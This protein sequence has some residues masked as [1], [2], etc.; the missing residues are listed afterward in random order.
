MIIIEKIKNNDFIDLNFNINKKYDTNNYRILSK[1]IK[2]NK[3]KII[4]ELYSKSIIKKK[5]IP[6]RILFHIYV[7][8]LNNDLEI[9][10]TN[11]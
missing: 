5:D 7:N 9:I 10:F 3:D 2:K 11:H 6:Y 1:Y 4:E 8:Y